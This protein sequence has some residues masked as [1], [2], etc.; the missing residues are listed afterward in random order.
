M[1]PVFVKD[2]LDFR[3]GGQSAGYGTGSGDMRS[4]KNRDSGIRKVE[5]D[6]NAITEK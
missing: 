5:T 4:L 1:I 6:F 2:G 3:S